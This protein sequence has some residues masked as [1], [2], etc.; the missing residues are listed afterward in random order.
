MRTK[1]RRVPL[2]CPTC[3]TLC[4][5][6]RDHQLQRKAAQGFSDNGPIPTPRFST[7]TLLDGQK[8]VPIL[9]GSYLPTK[10]YGWSYEKKTPLGLA[11]RRESFYP[12][13]AKCLTSKME[14]CVQIHMAS[15]R[16]TFII[17]SSSSS[18]VTSGFNNCISFCGMF[19]TSQFNYTFTSFNILLTSPTGQC[20]FQ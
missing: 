5:F 1:N 2:H 12:S 9:R 11:D 6:S 14:V 13:L 20:S 17:S 3:C 19:I 18:T 10:K 16:S 7:L 8:K 4:Y 15:I